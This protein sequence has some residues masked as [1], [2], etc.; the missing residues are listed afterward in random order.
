[1]TLLDVATG[2]PPIGR[3]RATKDEIEAAFVTAPEF[4]TST[5]RKELWDEFESGLGLLSGAVLVHA[6]WLGGSFFSNKIDPSDIDAVFVVNNTDLT[7]RTDADRQVVNAFQE[8]SH[9]LRL[10]SFILRWRPIAEWNYDAPGHRQYT[11]WRGYWDD[12]WCRIR[13]GMK[14]DPPVREDSIPRRGYLE[15]MVNDYS[16]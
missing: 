5:T 9:G 14:S 2:V 3:H 7:H 11:N 15:L 10:D 13:T 4:A 1:M 16:C 6:V 12:F 8:R